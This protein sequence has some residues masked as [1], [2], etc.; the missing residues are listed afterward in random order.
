MVSLFALLFS[1]LLVLSCQKE[2]SPGLI[3]RGNGIDSNGIGLLNKIVSTY[4]VD[5]LDYYTQEFEYDS[6]DRLWVVT[7][8]L[9][10]K[11][12]NGTITIKSGAVQ[13]FRD[14]LGRIIRIGSRPDTS[15]INSFINY[16][17]ATSGKVTSVYYVKTTAGGSTVIDSVEFVYDANNH[18]IRTNRYSDAF[19]GQIEG[20]QLYQYDAMGN[21][22]EHKNMLDLDSNGTF[23]VNFIFSWQYDNKIN[24]S[25][26]PEHA[27]FEWGQGWP[28]INS[29]NNLIKH[30]NFPP[31]IPNIEIVYSY[32]YDSLGRPIKMMHGANTNGGPDIYD[33]TNITKY[34]YN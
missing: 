22:T 5:N 34:Y 21:I 17:N 23:E 6:A 18:V 11:Q 9:K 31:S 4:T 15:S 2:I 28:I 25:Y 19:P 29:P 30:I 10:T 14:G 26:H 8:T 32:Q 1:L 3:Q 16:E 20:Y 7:N 12:A 33:S 27:L 13:F 24:P